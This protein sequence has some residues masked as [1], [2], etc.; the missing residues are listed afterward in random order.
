MTEGLL[1]QTDGLQKRKDILVL[2]GG[3]IP[4]RGGVDT[5]RSPAPGPA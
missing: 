5:S 1:T 2:A 4:A 3:T